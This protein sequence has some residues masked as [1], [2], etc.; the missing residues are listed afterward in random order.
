MGATPGEAGTIAHERLLALPPSRSTSS[1]RLTGSPMTASLG[2][3]CLR[4]GAGALALRPQG[5]VDAAL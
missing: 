1:T 4:R 3:W 2:Y 5:R